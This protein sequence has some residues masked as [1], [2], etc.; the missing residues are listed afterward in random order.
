MIFLSKWKQKKLR[1]SHSHRRAL[2]IPV[3]VGGQKADALV[4]L[5]RPPPAE[6]IEAPRLHLAGYGSNKQSHV[7]MGQN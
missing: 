5:F 3:R 4:G 6:G 1:T 7:A 2:P